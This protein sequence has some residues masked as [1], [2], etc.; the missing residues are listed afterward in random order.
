[1]WA[2]GA[3][4]APSLPGGAAP[5]VTAPPVEVAEGAEAE[6]EGAE[7]AEQASELDDDELV[8]EDAEDAPEA[9]QAVGQAAA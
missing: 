1:M 3:R 7:E 2:Q 4:R 6:E 9:G 5:L 8:V